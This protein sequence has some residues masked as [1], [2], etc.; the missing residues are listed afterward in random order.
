MCKQAFLDELREHLTGLPQSDVDERIAFYAEMIDDRMEEGLTEKEA[1]AAIGSV[2]EVYA[3]IIEETPFTKLVKERI[4]IK[5]KLTVWEI[6]LLAVGSP[7]WL[8]LLI[9]AFAVTLSLYVVLWSVVASLWAVFA[10]LA[11]SALGVLVG[12]VVILCYGHTLS[13]LV[14]IAVSLVCAGLS[15]FA[16]FG[17][18]AATKGGG[19][20]TKKMALVLKKCFV[21]KGQRNEATY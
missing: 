6:V 18:K 15:I 8:A 16:F 3:Q 20:L 11:A 12:G 17:C 7:I 14:C 1:V 4:R 9:A 13:G 2:E 21:R 10:S 5:R 19:W